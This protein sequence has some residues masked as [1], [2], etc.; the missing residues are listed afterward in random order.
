LAQ[1]EQ[2]VACT[3]ANVPASHGVGAVD[4]ALHEDPA[5]HGVQADAVLKNPVGH[6]ELQEDALGGEKEPTAHGEHD[7]APSPE[8]VPAGQ[9]SQLELIA[10][11]KR[12]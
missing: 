8:E 6:E 10:A 3:G 9:A 11:V 4:D 12:G 1:E 7:A 2:A 5:G